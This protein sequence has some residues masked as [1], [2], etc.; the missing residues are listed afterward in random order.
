MPTL[1]QVTSAVSLIAMAT[2]L[3]LGCYIVT[4][5]PRS[6]LAWLAG[7]TLW[8]LAGFFVD[9]LIST[10]PSPITDG[11]QGWPICF[12]LVLWYHLSLNMMPPDR[13]QRQRRFL[14]FVYAQAIL[15]DLLLATTSLIVVDAKQTLAA[16]FKVLTPGPAFLLLPI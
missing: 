11:W 7:I 8:A 1:A 15:L 4:R 12:S 10:N 14:F 2:S 5:S 13:G 6:R 3:W 9:V 16:T